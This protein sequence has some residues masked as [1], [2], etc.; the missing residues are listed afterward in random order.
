M[1]GDT[2]HRVVVLGG[3]LVGVFSARHLR[4]RAKGGVEVLRISRRDLFVSQ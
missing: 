1:P 4:R 3:R 2:N